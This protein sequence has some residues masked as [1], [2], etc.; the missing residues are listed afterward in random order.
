MI[1]VGSVHAVRGGRGTHS[2]ARSSSEA[3]DGVGEEGGE[4]GTNEQWGRLSHV[5]ETTEA[6]LDDGDGLLLGG[7]IGAKRASSHHSY[8]TKGRL[9]LLSR[10]GSIDSSDAG[11]GNIHP[12]TLSLGSAYWDVVGREAEGDKGTDSVFYSPGA[13]PSAQP[14]RAL[15]SGL[16]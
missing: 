14:P 7:R 8:L 4:E 3:S 13:W 5:L 9:P 11:L 16:L 1:T 2:A 10:N 12:H 6:F 15:H